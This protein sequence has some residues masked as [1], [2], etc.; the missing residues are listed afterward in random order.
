MPRA[1][2]K[3]LNI[4][5]A[6]IGELLKHETAVRLDPTHARPRHYDATDDHLCSP[7]GLTL[8]EV[9]GWLTVFK[10][11][12][13]AGREKLPLDADAGLE[14]TV[15]I[16]GRTESDLVDALEMI[17]EKIEAGYTSGSDG[18]FGRDYSFDRRG[19]EIEGDEDDEDDEI[20]CE[21]CGNTFPESDMIHNDDDNEVCPH[22]AEELNR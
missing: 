9:F 2:I 1:T 8:N 15:E 12:I 10:A 20:K 11:G 13:K 5:S 18:G 22:C 4:L 19:T 16:T 17:K 6:E 14:L 3:Q 21:K 7:A